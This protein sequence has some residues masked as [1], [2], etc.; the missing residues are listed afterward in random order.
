MSYTKEENEK[1]NENLKRNAVIKR[2]SN[3]N[4]FSHFSLKCEKTR[5][6]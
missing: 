3:Q 6:L 5:F 2:K 4:K 1:E